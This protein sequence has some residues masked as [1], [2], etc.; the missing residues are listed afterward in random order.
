MAVQYII[1]INV[2]QTTS[3]YYSAR[4]TVTAIKMCVSVS[5]LSDYMLMLVSC[6]YLHL[7]C[8]YN[9]RLA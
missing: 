9:Q 2:T 8:Q 3:T 7:I 4:F 5:R 6:F 1:I